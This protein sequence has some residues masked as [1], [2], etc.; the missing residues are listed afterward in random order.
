MELLIPDHQ[1]K[2]FEPV[3]ALPA[4]GQKDPCVPNEHLRHANLDEG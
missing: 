3:L 1:V 4:F 2:F